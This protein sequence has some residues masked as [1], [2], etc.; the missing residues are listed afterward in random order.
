MF[1]NR[2]KKIFPPGTF[3]PTPAR[4][5][6]IAHLCLAL[7]LLFWL[8]SEPFMG[9][10][11]ATKSKML[12]YQHLMGK[13]SLSHAQLFSELPDEKRSSI[14][15]DYDRLQKQLQTPFFRKLE[16]S[17]RL[18]WQLPLL[19]Q[20]WILF[21]I[22]IPILLLKKVEGSL[23]LVWILPLLTALYALDNRIEGIPIQL[24]QE[25]RLFPTEEFILK[26]YV[27]MPLSQSLAEQQR[28]LQ[29]GW[30]LYLIHNWAKESPADDP[31]IFTKQVERADFFFTVARID[32]L[33]QVS[34]SNRYKQESLFILSVYL[35]WNFSFALVV[36][37]VG[38]RLR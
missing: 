4:I 9:E 21:S 19:E 14:L 15:Y 10:L 1:R 12:S 3:I 26:E 11:F 5:F 22:L 25:Q 29:K 13:Q 7:T 33:K 2:E 17:M 31:K 8:A 27:K 35:F 34:I 23:S 16:A 6:A 36:Q 32:T 38:L 24:N 18:I 30:E 28:Q 20:G 37:R